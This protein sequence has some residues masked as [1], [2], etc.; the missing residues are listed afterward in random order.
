M[1]QR[2][3]ALVEAYDEQ[4]LMANSE[5]DMHRAY[6]RLV[7]SLCI[8]LYEVSGGRACYSGG[9]LKKYERKLCESLSY[10]EDMVRLMWKLIRG[11]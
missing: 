5:S 10:E 6:E 11:A 1:S 8:M 3:Y 2:T 7:G 4:C 9:V